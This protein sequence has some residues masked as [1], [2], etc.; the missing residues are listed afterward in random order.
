V[1]G[2]EHAA[3]RRHGA[4]VPRLDPAATL[5][6]H[7][8]VNA[9]T[10]AWT[11]DMPEG[12]AR[13]YVEKHGAAHLLSAD[14]VDDARARLADPAYMAAFPE[15]WDSE[16]QPLAAWRILGE[17]AVESA[18]L[19]RCAERD[20]DARDLATLADF[21]DAA[22]RPEAALVLACRV[23]TG[24]G[25]PEDLLRTLLRIA[26]LEERV[27]REGARLRV[28]EAL[29]AAEDALGPPACQHE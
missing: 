19:E 2:P 12:R 8:V 17:A 24:A 14:R 6:L 20:P 3:S 22:G 26:A 9:A 10:L 7:D 13:A 15:A 28:E 4:C 1:S 21:L 29:C 27:G 5:R 16:V 23:L 18:L 25:E 11:P